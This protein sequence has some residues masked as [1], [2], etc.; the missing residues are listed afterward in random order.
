VRIP[1]ARVPPTGTASNECA[2]GGFKR[3]DPSG[4]WGGGRRRIGV[5]GLGF[6][7]VQLHHDTAVTG[8]IGPERQVSCPQRPVVGDQQHLEAL[9]QGGRAHARRLGRQV[10]VVCREQRAALVEE[11]VQDGEDEPLAAGDRALPGLPHTRVRI[12][13]TRQ[14]GEP[15]GRRG[16]AVR[17]PAEAGGDLPIEHGH[18]LGTHPLNICRETGMTVQYGQ[19]VR[20][21]ILFRHIICR[22]VPLLEPSTWRSGPGHMH[23]CPHATPTRIVPSVRRRRSQL[24]AKAPGAGGAAVSPM[25]PGPGIAIR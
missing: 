4:A 1:L 7:Q 6:A 19:P 25:P 8:G 14:R 16:R 10:P 15:L 3:G 18:D 24:R 23:R 13:Q 11:G 20:I 21:G 9:L 5:E 22:H 2:Y 17:R 12:R